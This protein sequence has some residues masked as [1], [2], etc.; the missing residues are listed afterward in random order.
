MVHFWGGIL[1]PPVFPPNIAVIVPNS[2]PRKVKAQQFPRGQWSCQNWFCHWFRCEAHQAFLECAGNG[3]DL[4]VT[5]PRGLSTLGHWVHSPARCLRA[6]THPT[7]PGLSP[8]LTLRS[9]DF[10]Q[11]THSLYACFLTCK[12][13]EITLFTLQWVSKNL[14]QCPHAIS[15]Q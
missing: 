15:S 10:G 4:C 12:M 2:Q 14:V 5:Q 8:D 1:S 6:G 7:K 3:H 13:G 9:S 11:V